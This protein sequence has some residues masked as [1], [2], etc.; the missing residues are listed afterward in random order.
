MNKTAKS[1]L[2]AIAVIML[3]VF[4]AAPSS[5]RSTWDTSPVQVT[6]HVT[7][8]PKIVDLRVG[9]HSTYDRVVIDM[10]GP[11]PG[12]RISYVK[13]LYYDGSGETVPLRGARFIKITLTP[14]SAHDSQ[15]HSVYQGPRLTQYAMPTLRGAA[16]TGDFE[17]VVSFGISL[18]HLKS[19]RVFELH[20]PNRLVIDLH[21]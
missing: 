14:A 15:G 8:T 13:A 20:A 6:R 17:G 19:F 4:L 21:H 3:G 11:I 5:A 18:S 12:Y 9:Q 1:I 7:P 10:S 2:T 16:F